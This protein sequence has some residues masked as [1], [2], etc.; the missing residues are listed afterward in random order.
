MDKGENM[1]K[2]IFCSVLTVLTIALCSLGLVGCNSTKNA[3]ESD[4]TNK[5]ELLN[6]FEVVIDDNEEMASSSTL[7]PCIRLSS[8]ETTTSA[9]GV[10]KTLTATVYPED[11]TNVEVDWSIA[12]NAT[13]PLKNQAI[14]DYLV[15]NVAEDGARVATITCIKGFEGST[16]KITVTTRD[17]GYTATC[18]ASYA[19][20]PTFIHAAFN[21]FDTI[22]TYTC[23]TGTYSGNLYLSNSLGTSIDSSNAIGSGFGDYEIVSV[24]ASV[25][26]YVTAKYVNNGNVVYSEDIL[27]D[28]TDSFNGHA[29]TINRTYDSAQ[30]PLNLTINGATFAN[31]SIS[32]STLTVNIVKTQGSYLFGNPATRTGWIVEYKG[33]YYAAQG[34]GVPNPCSI[35][36]LVKELNSGLEKLLTFNM[37]TSASSVTLSE[38][39]LS[40]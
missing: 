28:T 29:Q 32:G 23:T 40:F 36:V 19:G 9:E 13:A 15:L 35:R 30:F 39:T 11:A 14:S 16:A 2:K 17:G 27:I 8:G 26:Y 6:N 1:F 22:D 37:V 24:Y 5:N 20:V 33:A 7:T 21:G 3:S 18:T 4:I 38:N 34:G 10:V 31:A 25:K 12:W